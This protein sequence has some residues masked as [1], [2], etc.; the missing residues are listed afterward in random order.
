[1]CSIFIAE[2]FR[3]TATK[4]RSGMPE[5]PVRH[6]HAHV[7]TVVLPES[8]HRGFAHPALLGCRA[9]AAHLDQRLFV[10]GAG[11][12]AL[13][14]AGGGAV[15]HGDEACRTDQIGLP[16]PKLRQGLVVGRKAEASPDKLGSIEALRHHAADS[17]AVAD[18]LQHEAG[19]YGEDLQP[20]AVA[21]FVDIFQKLFRS[22]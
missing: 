14:E 16:E 13:D 19:E 15:L 18:L 8:A 3:C 22:L 9:A 4:S 17:E 11:N 21:E 5:R 20:D 7:M 1:M 6:L 12:P 10:A 2:G